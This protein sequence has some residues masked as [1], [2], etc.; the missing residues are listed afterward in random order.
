MDS[1][2]IISKKINSVF[3]KEYIETLKKELGQ[4]KVLIYGAGIA[5]EELNE[6]FSLEG[7]N[8]VGISDIKFTREGSWK[9]LKTIPPSKINQYDFDVILMTL[10]YPDR[11]IK[12]LSEGGQINE[13]TDIRILFKEIIPN[14]HE[15]IDYL[16][17]LNFEKHLKKLSN[18]LKNKK[19]VI[20]GAGAFFQAINAYYDL[21]KL[22]IIALAD[23][24]FSQHESGEKF[25]N[26]PVC[27][28]LEIRE[29]K[30]DY[31]LVAT[32]YFVYILEELEDNILY[33][34]KIKILPLVKKSFWELFKEIWG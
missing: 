27:A 31:V 17:G 12:A 28:P 16:E 26:Y 15:L 18:K 1:N 25:L 22:N 34:S 29:L 4:K 7:L 24:K 33:N 10:Y 20:Y 21:S 9:G 13:N 8:V 30:P 6:K 11:A 14:E 2:K 32:R 19:V 23:R 5:F 3:F